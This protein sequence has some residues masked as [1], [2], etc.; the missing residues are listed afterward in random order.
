MME[1]V[2]TL[3]QDRGSQP[4][5]LGQVH[6]EPV[7]PALVAPD[8]FGAGMAEVFLDLPASNP[9]SDVFSE[10]VTLWLSI[11]PAVGRASRRCARRGRSRQG[12]G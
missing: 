12:R 8:H 10:V 6:A 4:C 7:M 5:R 9:E 1:S 2:A 11:T 3:Q